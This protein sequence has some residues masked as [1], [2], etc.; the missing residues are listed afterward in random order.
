MSLFT[1]GRARAL[2]TAAAVALAIPFVL[3]ACSFSTGL[4]TI[5]GADLSKQVAD[6]FEQQLN[7]RP[8]VDC[9][10]DPIQLVNGAIV[11]CDFSATDDPTTHY[12]S[13]TTISNVNGGDF[14]IDTKV[15]STPK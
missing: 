8:I 2:T 1:R 10:T 6:Q 11:H 7:V 9:G 15:A 12:D 3:S 13:T 5:S 4:A 14:H